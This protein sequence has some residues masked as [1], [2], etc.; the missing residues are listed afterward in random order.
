MLFEG[1]II[2]KLTGERLLSYSL[3]GRTMGFD[4]ETRTWSP[5]L[6]QAAGVDPA[7]MSKPVASGTPAGPILPALRRKLGIREEALVV[8][9]GH[10]QMC[11]AVGAGAVRDGVAANGSG[12]VEVLSVTLPE[13][14]D[15][16][17]LYANNYTLSIHADPAR[18]FTYCCN[19]TGSL[20]LSW[21]LSNFG[22]PGTFAAYEAH[23]PKKPT[24]LLVL[25]YVAGAGTPSMDFAARGVIAGMDVTTTKYDVYRALMEGLA[26]D[27]V[28]NMDLLRKA[29]VAVEEIRATGGGALSKMWLQIKADVTGLPVY[30]LASHQAGAMGCM[31][32]AA[33][34]AGLYADLDEAVADLVATREVFEPNAANHR[35]YQDRKEEFLALFTAAPRSSAATL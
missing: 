35:F 17:P 21:F 14:A 1:F 20:L 26:F 28:C 19:S 7:L 25:P 3:A 13:R 5:A 11:V 30:T 33:V 27:L 8:T 32:L 6:F 24:Q 31:I 34:A 2:Y 23:A 9:G 4:I 15:P 16:H 12:T 10:D 29:S 18:V 22:D